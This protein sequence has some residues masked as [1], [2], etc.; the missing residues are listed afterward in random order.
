MNTMPKTVIKESDM[1]PAASSVIRWAGIAAIVAGAIFAGIQPV[2][3]ADVI[4][5][6][7]T[8][9]WLFITYL[10]TAMS[11]FGLLGIAGLYARQ[12]KKMGWLGFAGFLLLMTFYAVQ[13]TYSF[14]E[15]FI[16]P[17]LTTIAP[18][19]VSSTLEMGASLPMEMNLGAFATVYQLVSMLYLLGTLLFGIATFRARILSRWAGLLLALAG[20]LALVMVT[21]LPH[22]N[23]RLAA[24]PMGIALA[25][26]GYSLWSERQAPALT[27]LPGVANPQPAHTGA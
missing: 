2:H 22:Q 5:S 27:A 26:L 10:K 3:P 13:M 12:V 19:F 23:A 17:L 21:V 6:V 14:A 11:V 20:P 9:F 24:M 4:S 16:L 1:R 15:A 18:T 7:G 25:W 8:N